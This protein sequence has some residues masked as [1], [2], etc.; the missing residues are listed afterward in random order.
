MH[1]ALAPQPPVIALEQHDEIIAPDMADE[2][3]RLIGIRQDQLG[4]ELDHLVTPP[5]AVQVVVG[6][7]IVQ[8]EIGCGVLHPGIEQAADVFGDGNVARQE[9][10]RVGMA[11]SLDAP[12]RHRAHEAL[13]GRQPRIAAALRDDEPLVQIALIVSGEYG[14]ERIDRRAGLDPQGRGVHEQ[15]ARAAPI[16]LARIGLGKLVHEVTPV[17]QTDGVVPIDHGHGMQARMLREE[18]HQFT[19]GRRHL[20]CG[21]L[22]PQAPD[23]LRQVG[24][25]RRIRQ[26]RNLGGVEHLARCRRHRGLRMGRGPTE[27]VALAEVASEVAQHGEFFHALDPFG[28]QGR[29][30]GSAQPEYGTHHLD[31]AAVTMDLA[32][33][34]L[35]QLDHLRLELRPQAQAGATITE[36][37]ER[38]PHALPGKGSERGL[39]AVD[40]LHTLMLGEFQD[41]ARGCKARIHRAPDEAPAALAPEAGD[42][43]RAEIDEELSL[44][45]KRGERLDGALGGIDLERARQPALLCDTEQVVRLL[46][47]RTRGAAHQGLVAEEGRAR[48]ID[49]G[50]KNERQ[51][52]PLEHVT[53]PCLAFLTEGHVTPGQQKICGSVTEP[54]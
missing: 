46:E 2:V 22:D 11:R 25:G 6:L 23:G 27:Q 9:G 51:L 43:R 14:R 54:R 13:A 50:L 24:A 31:V 32:N 26:H 34:E 37:I 48:E 49:D 36:I 8:V 7:E 12:L 44:Q 41:Q 21:R 20:D 38:Q 16:E 45:L 47:R 40:I 17:H 30:E 18:L 33:E 29:T 1:D 28:Y 15:R 53:Q 10:E 35:V 4:S 5:V 52:A 3:L 19:V 42:Q 39:Q